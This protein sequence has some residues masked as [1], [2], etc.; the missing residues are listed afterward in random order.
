MSEKVRVLEIGS[1]KESHSTCLPIKP[2]L[3]GIDYVMAT[4]DAYDLEKPDILHDIRE[5]IPPLYHGAFD[6]VFLSHVLEHIEFMRVFWVVVNLIQLL[7]EGG[8]LHIAVPDLEWAC[9]KVLQGEDG[10]AT[11]G[12][13]WGGQLNEWDYHKSGYTLHSLRILMES[14]GLTIRKAGHR[15]YISRVTLNGEERDEAV[16]MNYIVGANYPIY[17]GERLDNG[18]PV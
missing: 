13:F 8:E 11:A 2:E 18:N 15:Q 16:L 14:A 9:R 1:G 6:I 10:I 5:P 3:A 12:V 7:T 4:M 17:Y